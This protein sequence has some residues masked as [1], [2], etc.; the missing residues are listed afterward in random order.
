MKNVFSHSCV[1]FSKLWETTGKSQLA[2]ADLDLAGPALRRLLCG[3]R[4]TL[5]YMKVLTVR[6]T[7]TSG[8][9]GKSREGS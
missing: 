1:T 2:A 5:Q 8:F 3:T 4:F 6:C 9:Q 7:H